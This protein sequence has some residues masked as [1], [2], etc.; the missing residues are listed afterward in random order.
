MRQ[1]KTA[2]EVIQDIAEALGQAD[3]EFIED[4]ANRVISGRVEYV[5]DSLFEV[6]WDNAGEGTGEDELHEEEEDE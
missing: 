2:D 5:E 4:I 6:F 1:L 3:G